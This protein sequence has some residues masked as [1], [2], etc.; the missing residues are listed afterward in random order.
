MK[1]IAQVTSGLDSFQALAVVQSL[2]ALA[3]AGRIVI[4][5]IHQPRQLIFSEFD[6]L[7]VLTEGMLIYSG[8]R[9]GLEPYLDS[10][11]FRIPP[12]LNVAHHLLDL[13]S[14]DQR[15]EHKLAVSRR[16]IDAMCAHFAL[17]SRE[18]LEL[19][20]DEDEDEGKVGIEKSEHGIAVTSS[21]SLASSSIFSSYYPPLQPPHT[22][23]PTLLGATV[24]YAHLTVVLF[25][26][27]T[28][29]ML[30]DNN[31]QFI[32]LGVLV[33][34]AAVLSLL[35]SKHDT[36]YDLSQASIQNRIGLLFFVVIPGPV[37][38]VA[39]V[40]SQAWP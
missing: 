31:S 39:K 30:R 34:M 6:R 38:D 15:D 24:K 8:R 23:K 9:H 16:R 36:S 29:E 27:A 33:F 11:D 26:R 21:S 32:K 7:S 12:G 14:L 35:Y 19:D 10:M 1:H 5:T 20:E 40:R 13:V 28:V 22:H 4:M 18:R 37:M 17:V 25:W 3:R 2:K